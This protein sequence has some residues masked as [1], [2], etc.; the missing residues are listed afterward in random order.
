MAIRDVQM[1]VMSAQAFT[2]TAVSGSSIDVGGANRDLATGEPIE[3]VAT[4]TVAGDRTTGDETYTLEAIQADNDVL[5]T[6]VEVLA[7]RPLRAASE[8]AVGSQ[9]RLP[10]PGGSITR[11]YIGARMT[12]A[13]TTPTITVTA[14]FSPSSMVS[15]PP[16]SYPKGY[17]GPS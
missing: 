9:I 7:S 10:I 6:N 16:Q 1:R 5:T 8:L 11:R 3:L 13:G 12:L 15:G 2:A 4:V 14:F 17:T